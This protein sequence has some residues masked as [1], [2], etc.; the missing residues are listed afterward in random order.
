MSAC[1]ASESSNPGTSLQ[2]TLEQEKINVNLGKGKTLEPRDAAEGIKP[3]LM[4][5]LGRQNFV[6]WCLS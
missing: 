6:A 5:C 4:F 3:F 1:T 2:L